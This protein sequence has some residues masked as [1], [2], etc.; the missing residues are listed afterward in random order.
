M[1]INKNKTRIA[2]LFTLILKQMD[3]IRPSQMMRMC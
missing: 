1:K 2:Q 3:Q